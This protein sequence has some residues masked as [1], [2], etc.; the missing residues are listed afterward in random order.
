[1]HSNPTLWHDLCARLAQLS[2][3]FLQVQ[4]NAGAAVVQLFDSWAGCLSEADYRE[5]VFPHSQSIFTA[6]SEQNPVVPTIHFGVDTG[7]LLTAMSEAGADVMGVDWRTPLP[8]AA[9]LVGNR[10][11]QGNL[12]PALLL[13]P[14]SVV[15]REVR[16]VMTE[17]RGLPGHI[18]NLGHGVLPETDP[19]LLTR[20]V[21]LV[22]EFSA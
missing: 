13:A 7:H 21:E 3:A 16:R 8:V 18:F 11:L 2:L 14:E 4:V 17:A 19:D 10:P 5:Y 12:D 6:L 15:A 20:V 22:H 9:G 1:M